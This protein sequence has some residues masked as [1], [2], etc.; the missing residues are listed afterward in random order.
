MADPE[1]AARPAPDTNADP[2][3]G[4]RSGSGS[5]SGSGSNKGPDTDTGAGSDAGSGPPSGPGPLTVPSMSAGPDF[6]LR[7]WEMSDLPLI[8][9]AARD[10]YIPLI[11]TVPAPYSDQAAE[12]FVR[13]QWERAATGTGYPFAIVRSRDRRPVGAIGL[14]L[15]DL[16]EGRASIGYWMVASG[17]GLGVARAALRTVTGWALRDLGIPRLQ[18]FV[19]PWNAA[20]ARIAEDVG[21]RREGL[22]RGWQQVGDERRDMAVYALLNSDGPGD[23]RAVAT[24]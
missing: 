13:E 10:P 14:W 3:P 8:R 19:E 11:T 17:R 2:A 5:G 16:P 9:E 7:P 12:A 21:Y 6:V 1:P 4:P 20:S 22:L 15:R 18:L 23:G 24:D